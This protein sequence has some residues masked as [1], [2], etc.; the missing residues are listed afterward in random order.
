MS[1][2]RAGR[3]VSVNVNEG[4]VPKLPVD[5]QWVGSLGLA[6]DRHIE[7]E[8]SHGGVDQAVCLYSMEA[9]GRLVAEGHNAFPGAF[10]ENLTL[11]GIELDAIGPGDRLAIG[12]G[13]LVIEITRHAAPCK[14]QAQ[15][16]SDGRFA[17]ISGK[18]NPPDAR[19]Y[20]RVLN[21]GPVRP[22]DAVR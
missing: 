19:W 2:P 17:R 1:E 18:T 22:G 3:V 4:G 20:A 5:E 14:K 10:G 7:P 9:I 13:G 21:E 16:F 8:P 11:E 12:D 6:D 15:W